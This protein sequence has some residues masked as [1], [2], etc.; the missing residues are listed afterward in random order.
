M[1]PSTPTT[2][3]WARATVGEVVQQQQQQHEAAPPTK[4]GD[5]PW[6]SMLDAT[7]ALSTANKDERCF[8]C[9][10]T[11][12][13]ALS[14]AEGSSHGG[15][16]GKLR[17]LSRHPAL[18]ANDAGR[19]YLCSRCARSD[20]YELLST[21]EAQRRFRLKR[22]GASEL[23]RQV[24]HIRVGSS[25]KYWVHHLQWV[26]DC[27][28]ALAGPDDDD[29]I[30]DGA[31][32]VAKAA[33][34]PATKQR[35]QQNDDSTKRKK[36][37]RTASAQHHGA[38]ASPWE[39]ALAMSG[40]IMP[41][42]LTMS[43]SCSQAP[44][45]HQDPLPREQVGVEHQQQ[46]DNDDE[47]ARA[48]AFLA[49]FRYTDLFGHLEAACWAAPSFDW[50]S[51]G[52]SDC[53]GLIAESMSVCAPPPHQTLADAVGGVLEDC[54]ASCTSTPLYTDDNGPGDEEDSDSE[55]SEDVLSAH[56]VKQRAAQRKVELDQIRRDVRL[57]HLFSAMKRLDRGP[58]HADAD[59]DADADAKC[60]DDDE[61]SDS[62]GNDRSTTHEEMFDWI[63]SRAGA[64]RQ[65]ALHAFVAGRWK[66]LDERCGGMGPCEVERMAAYLSHNPLRPQQEGPAA[67]APTDEDGPLHS[68][69]YH[70]ETHVALH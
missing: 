7:A 43:G 40:V 49:Q 39:M 3:S 45:S 61:D 31:E 68:E 28:Q 24:P 30:V 55:D 66:E 35:Q 53:L 33:H 69:H 9:G 32:D 26:A 34:Q 14:A 63:S 42:T 29:V 65:E 11:L 64:Q 17:I 1:E 47:A 8:E 60:N 41:V 20:K 37:A 36:R 57:E 25:K 59:A 27:S 67:A 21:K 4:K 22:K 13:S 19:T 15:D 58:C 10:W 12:A 54:E 18:Q 5:W 50:P 38:A 46:Q 23:L 6:Q 2:P 16:E 44:V 51:T 48:E 62:N 52:E 70:F 56:E